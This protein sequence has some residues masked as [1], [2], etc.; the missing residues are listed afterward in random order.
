[1][2]HSATGLDLAPVIATVTGDVV[3]IVTGFVLW[4]CCLEISA[5]IAVAAAC[6]NAAMNAGIVVDYIAVIAALKTTANHTVATSRDSA[7]VQTSITIISVT[8]VT[9]FAQL[10]K[11]ITTAGGLTII[12]TAVVVV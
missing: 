5:S 9:G 12:Q 1:M 3:T 11:S 2:N 6:R 7:R 4:L 10:H 8:I